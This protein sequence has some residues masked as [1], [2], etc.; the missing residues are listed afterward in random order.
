MLKKVTTCAFI[1]TLISSVLIGSSIIF[2]NDKGED[3]QAKPP[4][5]EIMVKQASKDPTLLE[6]LNQFSDQD[7][8]IAY[9]ENM[10]GGFSVKPADSSEP[11]VGEILDTKGNKVLYRDAQSVTIAQVKEAIQ[12]K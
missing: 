6:I 12:N 8:I 9:P 2:A 10:G 5:L 4:T 3:I 11:L 7:T 1:I